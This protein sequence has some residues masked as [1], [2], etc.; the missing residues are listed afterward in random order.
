MPLFATR[1]RT[2]TRAHTHIHTH[3]HTYI[4]STKETYFIHVNILKYEGRP[5]IINPLTVYRG[6]VYWV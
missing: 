5:Y 4:N 6:T 3:I 2:H 1:T